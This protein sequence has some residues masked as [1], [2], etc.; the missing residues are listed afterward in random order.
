MIQYQ[1]SKDYEYYSDD[2]SKP[3]GKIRSRKYPQGLLKKTKSP[4]AYNINVRISKSNARMRIL[5]LSRRFPTVCLGYATEMNW[6][7]GTGKTPYR[8]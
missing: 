3:V 6:P 2:F 5:F 8:D 1:P 7:R 4:V